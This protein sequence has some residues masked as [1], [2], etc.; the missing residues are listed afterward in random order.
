[1][2]SGG[3]GLVSQSL[4]VC[5]E[6]SRPPKKGTKS[7][8]RVK[9]AILLDRTTTLFSVYL[10]GGMDLLQCRERLFCSP[11]TLRDFQ[12]KAGTVPS[13]AVLH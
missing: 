5:S 9:V 4:P 1:M 2:D 8:N 6:S 11:V 3:V 7:N 12:E 10:F 13:C